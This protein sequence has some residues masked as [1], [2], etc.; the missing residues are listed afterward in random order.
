MSNIC[1]I[2]HISIDRIH[3]NKNIHESIGGPPCYSGITC[4][5][6]GHN[7]EVLTKVGK[8]FPDKYNA[9]HSRMVAFDFRHYC[10]GPPPV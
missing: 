4:I 2:G 9:R 5:N 10:F 7:V 1:I 8:D 6:E 3:D